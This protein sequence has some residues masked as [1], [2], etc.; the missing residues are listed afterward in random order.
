[1]QQQ[2]AK[3]LVK[4][5]KQWAPNPDAKDVKPTA[6]LVAFMNRMQTIQDTLF[7]GTPQLHMSYTLKPVPEQNVEAITLSIDGHASTSTKGSAQAQPFT[8]PGSGQVSVIVKAGGNI[9][10]GAYQG[11]WAT[12]RWMYD[13]DPRTAGGSTMQWSTVKQLHGQPQAPT[14]A[15]GHPIV[16]KVEVQSGADIFDRNFF[17]IRCPAK[18]TE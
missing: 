15:Q 18:V 10:F 1:M 14:D 5:G 17:N 8:W 16:M 7:G 9:P 4:Q 2:L 6:D 11:T 3:L 12:W 13:A